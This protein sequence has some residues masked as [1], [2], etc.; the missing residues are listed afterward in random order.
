MDA[1]TTPP[2]S[3]G[4]K[5]FVVGETATPPKP[6]RDTILALIVK[7]IQAKGPAMEQQIKERVKTGQKFNVKGCEVDSGLLSEALKQV[8]KKAAA[9]TSTPSAALGQGNSGVPGRPATAGTGA[10]AP[11]ATMNTTSRWTASAPSAAAL[12]QKALQECE[13]AEPFVRKVRNISQ[14]KVA[15]FTKP[16]IFSHA[17]GEH[18]GPGEVVD[19]IARCSRVQ[20]GR[21]YLRLRRS[22]GW[23]ST[24]AHQDIWKMILVEAESRSPVEP[25][26]SSTTFQSRA[27]QVLSRIDASGSGV[28][29]DGRPLQGVPALNQP[30][31]FRVAGGRGQSILSHPSVSA[32]TC[33]TLQAWDEFQADAVCVV[34]ME[35]RAYLRIQG[36]R[37]WM[38]ERTRSDISRYAVEPVGFSVPHDDHRPTRPA[39]P[40]KMIG[41][42]GDHSARPHHTKTSVIERTTLEQD[43]ESI[44]AAVAAAAKPSPRCTPLKDECVVLRSDKELWPK[45]LGEPRPI[46]HEMRVALRRASRV[47][48]RKVKEC[49]DDLKEVEERVA[50]FARACDGKKILQGHADALRKEITKI[51]EEWKAAIE[52]DIAGL[53]ALPLAKKSRK[54]GSGIVAP[55][56][57]LG[58]AWHCAM[59]RTEQISNDSG[60]TFV[61]HFGPLR[62]EAAVASEDL[63]ALSEAVSKRA[64]SGIIDE[65]SPTMKK[66]KRA[67]SGSVDEES[68]TLKKQRTA[69][70]AM[71][72]D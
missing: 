70:V 4:G 19:V 17:I 41:L 60:K 52:K 38:C 23:V 39:V 69:A 6:S 71:D 51:E 58:E 21:T 55:V 31:T 2:S 46:K 43:G 35:G 28:D 47:Y 26:G 48:F 67:A 33:G 40:R 53:D 27:A 63:K 15:I 22:E 12:A 59:I 8:H 42:S 45:Q 61:Q 16:N 56:Q 50:S 32:S 30:R 14:D 36:N 24:R 66:S 9:T 44:K 62:A 64:A 11:P 10:T 49:E 1:T 13:T 3:T 5:R 65:D 29:T 25:I 68:P 72:A 18:I 37:G 57:V 7:L 34:H 54:S 20:D